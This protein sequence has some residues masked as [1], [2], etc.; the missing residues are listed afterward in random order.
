M[1]LVVKRIDFFFVTALF[2]VWNDLLGKVSSAVFY[3]FSENNQIFN[4][5]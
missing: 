2:K 3:H 1:R 5:I 4:F